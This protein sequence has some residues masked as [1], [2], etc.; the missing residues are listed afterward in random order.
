MDNCQTCS[1]PLTPDEIGLHKKLFCRAAE[2]FRCIRCN[3]AY[4]EV[5]E[6]LLQDKIRQ[7]KAMGCT[8]FEVIRE[9]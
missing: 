4:L 9:G 8:L 1:R 7:F 3:A 5:E 6:S 2:E